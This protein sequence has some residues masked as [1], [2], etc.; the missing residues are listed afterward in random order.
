MRF[1]SLHR[2]AYAGAAIALLPACATAPSTTMPSL[3]NVGYAQEAGSSG[4]VFKH[5]KHVVLIVQEARSFENLFAGFKGADAPLYGLESDGRRIALHAIGW[6][7]PRVNANIPS[8][9]T[10]YDGGKMDRFNLVPLQNGRPSGAAAYAYLE[11]SLVQPY[12]QMASDNVLADRMFPPTWGDSSAFTG[13]LDLIAGTAFI[14]PNEEAI[15]P[16]NTP[17]GCDAPRGTLTQILT[18]QGLSGQPPSDPAPWGPFPCFTSFSTLAD[19]LDGADVSWKYYAPGISENYAGRVWS[20]FRAI[21]RVYR[22]R[23]WSERVV[24]PETQILK[25]VAS[26]TL[27]AMAW[28]V[29]ASQNSDTGGGK[30]GPAWVSSI[31]NAIGKSHYWNDTAIVVIWDG[32]GGWYDD[33]PPP[34]LDGWGLGFRVPCIVISSF[35]RVHYVSH[36]SYEYGS[37]LKFIEEA[38]RLP[39]LGHTDERAT[40]IA[41]AFDFGNPPHPFQPIRP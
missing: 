28:V 10:A 12:W 8:E 32:Y 29:P 26:G 2:I 21:K 41:G 20:A 3:A 30:G 25:D 38:F 16:T 24:S 5:I 1:T 39:S 22:G 33:A 7:A 37:I 14:K 13:H 34:Q 19:T 9:W 27:P 35:A 11:H 15:V 31:V 40:S 6:N 23:D 18:P 17:W 36:T 4:T